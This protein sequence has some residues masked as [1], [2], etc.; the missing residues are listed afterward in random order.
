M[1]IRILV[2]NVRGIN[3]A[4]TANHV[5]LLCKTHKIHV[6]AIL[7]PMTP[8]NFPMFCNK[9]GFHNGIANKNN[10]IW[11]FWTQSY[12]ASLLRDC[13]QVLDIEFQS[14]ALSHKFT[15]SF[16]YAK[17]TRVERRDLWDELRA[18]AT[19]FDHKPWIVGGDFNCFLAEEERIR[20][21]TNRHLDM[22]EFGQMASDSGLIDIGFEGD[23]MH[24]WCR[25]GLKE[26][27]DRIFMNNTWTDIFPKSGVKHL[28]RI[29]S[30]HAPLLFY[31]DLSIHKPPPTFRYLNIAQDKVAHLEKAYDDNPSPHLLIDLNHA[32]VE[33]VLATRIEEDYWHQKSS[34]KWI[35]EG[36]RNTKYFHNLVKHKR[37]K[38][39]IHSIIDN[40]ISLTDEKDIQHSCVNF[41]TSYLANDVQ[42]AEFQCDF[43][44]PT[45]PDYI[46]LTALCVTPSRTEAK[47]A[48]RPSPL[49]A[50]VAALHQA[51]RLLPPWHISK[52]WIGSD[53]SILCTTINK[54]LPGHWSIKDLL[55]DIQN[56]LSLCAYQIS[57]VY[58]EGNKVADKLVDIGLHTENS[59]EYN[60]TSI[61]IAVKKIA[62]LDQ[63]NLPSFR[64]EN[65]P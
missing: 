9:L 33:L 4:L 22:E 16:V 7:E 38:S 17:C 6:L 42:C 49:V 52:L 55:V 25:R 30:H 11:V 58:K 26:R 63:I 28:P 5:H 40:G 14:G 20:S 32:T 60:N 46:D 34:C 50:E 39:R 29:K 35:V 12:S 61:P 31:A 41:F 13:E 8:P 53:S 27:L 21:N 57:H 54:K 56:S 2:W 3:N 23:T 10:K 24:T 18:V 43:L 36:E 45:I 44:I 64:L 51:L 19:L 1:S 15:A 37:V 48:Q 62:R 59:I 65:H 47:Q